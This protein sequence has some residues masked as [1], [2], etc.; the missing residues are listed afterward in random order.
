MRKPPNYFTE[1]QYNGYGQEMQGEIESH[2]SDPAGQQ[3]RI[4]PTES[5]KLTPV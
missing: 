5:I 1:Q 4:L 3:F 2:P